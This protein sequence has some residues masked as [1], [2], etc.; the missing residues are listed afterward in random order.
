MLSISAR[1]NAT[2]AE[3]YLETLRT[4]RGETENALEDYY[5]AENSGHW[6]GSGAYELGLRGTVKDGEFLALARGFD[7]H[8]EALTQNSGEES[9]RAGWDLTFSSPKSVSVAWALADKNLRRAIE[10]AHDGA[11]KAGLDYVE[12][13]ASRSRIGHAGEF[14]VPAKLVASVYR[15]GTSREQDPQLH[16]HAFVHNV[17]VRE[18]GSTGALQSRHFYVWQKAG[19]AAYRVALAAQLKNLGYEVER[20][21]ESFRLKQVPREAEREFSTRRAQIAAELEQRGANSARAREI[22]TLATR[23]AKENCNTVEL[24]KDWRERAENFQMRMK[25]ILK[26]THDMERA[27]TDTLPDYDAVRDKLTEQNS[28]FAESQ[29][30]TVMLQEMQGKADLALAEA[31]VEDFLEN[32]P[33]VLAVEART[34]YAKGGK[35]YTTPEMLALETRLMERS[36]RLA[37][38]CGHEVANRDVAESARYGQLSEEQRSFVEH[39]TG[40]GDLVLA[41]GSAGSGKT[42]ALGAAC[43]AWEA[44]GYQVH[45][46]TLSGAAADELEKG[47]GIKS[48]TVARF[49]GERFIET[50]AGEIQ[51]VTGISPPGAADLNTRSIVVLDEAGM[52]GSR[53]MHE[54]TRRIED[55]G[56][57]LVAVGDSSQLQAIEAGAAFRALSER[58][59]PILMEENRRQAEAIDRLAVA[60]LRAGNSEAALETLGNAGRLHVNDSAREAK[61]KLGCALA[62]DLADGKS[63]I[64]IAATRQD[65]ADINREAREAAITNGSVDAAQDALALTRSGIQAFAP[66]DRVVF[67]RNVNRGKHAE[68]LGG[69]VKNGF[70]GTVMDSEQRY[71]EDDRPTIVKLT[72]RLDAGG[73]RSVNTSE[74]DHIGYGYAVTAHKAQGATVATAHVLGTEASM[75]TG[76]EWS[77]VAG[78]RH[79]SELHIYSDTASMAQLAPDWAQS[80]QKDTTLDYKV[81]SKHE[82][83]VAPEVE[84]SR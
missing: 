11:V 64:G 46:V 81:S 60:Q 44:T 33:G 61:T 27:Q 75:P 52:V 1:G 8:G 29:A 53:Q 48:T 31:E 51:R 71:D 7:T 47:S 50:E 56:A 69:P 22:A 59:A 3:K 78:S 72:I 30:H 41:Q 37:T 15:H 68:R 25:P 26:P 28:T 74:Y 34:A 49:L 20:D 12:R 18:D 67:E 73:D 55:A 76:R 65:A 80:Y 5:A 43:K 82:T 21:G 2:S 58:V 9:H 54:I 40:S 57:K 70:R 62:N 39:V 35:R 6:A 4:G 23:K 45:G 19:G 14:E 32:D 16:S 17:C 10:K 63:T 84:I 83:E 77:Y 79:R 13:H 42:Y 66:G 36:E 38:R 24:R